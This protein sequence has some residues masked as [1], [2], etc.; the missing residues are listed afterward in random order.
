MLCPEAHRNI[1][2]ALSK[3]MVEAQII[4]QT[5]KWEMDELVNAAYWHAVE[6]LNSYGQAFMTCYRAMAGRELAN[7]AA[8]FTT[9]TQSQAHGGSGPLR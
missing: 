5:E 3:D 8:A 6:T 7:S 9:P 1:C 4:D 2:F